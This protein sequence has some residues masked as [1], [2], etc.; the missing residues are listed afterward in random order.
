MATEPKFI[1]GYTYDN[2]MLQHECP[3]AKH[4]H[5]TPRRLSSI[6]DRCRELKILDRCLFVP[7]TKATDEDILLY[8]DPNYYKSV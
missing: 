4:H 5:E 8:H 6:I 1:T 3:W 7:S 2:V